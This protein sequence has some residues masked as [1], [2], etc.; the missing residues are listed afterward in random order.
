MRVGTK[1]TNKGPRLIQ[2]NSK[3]LGIFTKKVLAAT[4][5]GR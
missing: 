4:G 2:L 3:Q 5:K 1:W